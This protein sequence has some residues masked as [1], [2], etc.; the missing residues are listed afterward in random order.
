MSDRDSS[1]P[2]ATAAVVSQTNPSALERGIPAKVDA[3]LRENYPA[4]HEKFFR[5][6]LERKRTQSGHTRD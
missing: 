3:K 1:M 2:A 5:P 6:F 4:Q